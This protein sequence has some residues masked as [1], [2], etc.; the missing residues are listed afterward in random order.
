MSIVSFPKRERNILFY[1]H[2]PMY[3]V[4][5]PIIVL[6]DH[7]IARAMPVHVVKEC[8]HHLASILDESSHIEFLM[9]F[10]KELL[11]LHTHELMED[12]EFMRPVMNAVKKALNARVRDNTDM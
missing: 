11:Q 8:L 3:L 2:I 10:I 5:F 7:S 1:K 9:L 4:K 6:I 12:L